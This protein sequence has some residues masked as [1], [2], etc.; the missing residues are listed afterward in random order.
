[1]TRGPTGEGGVEGVIETRGE[2]GVRTSGCGP[3]GTSL[4]TG[5]EG[6]LNGEGPEP[7]EV[8]PV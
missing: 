7:T 5:L 2:E 8:P 6:S 1:M 3:D 4:Q